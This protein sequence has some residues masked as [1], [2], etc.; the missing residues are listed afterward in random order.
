MGGEA[1]P[2]SWIRENTT[3]NNFLGNGGTEFNSSSGW[4]DLPFRN[5]DPVLGR[6]N[7]VDP[8]ADKYASLTPYNFSFNDPVTFNDPSGAKPPINHYYG[9]YFTYDDWV[10]GRYSDWSPSIDR[11]GAGRRQFGVSLSFEALSYSAAGMQVHAQMVSDARTMTP[12]E[13][14]AKYGTP[15]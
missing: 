10:P 13:Y 4:Y 2:S 1:G 9:N 6:M 8:M 12:S 14:G 11:S 3:G 7:G 15:V 5:Y